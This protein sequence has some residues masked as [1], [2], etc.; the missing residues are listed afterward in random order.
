MISW[1]RNA[2]PALIAERNALAVT[3]G[4]TAKPLVVIVTDTPGLVAASEILGDAQQGVVYCRSS[5]LEAFPEYGQDSAMREHCELHSFF[6]DEQGA[7]NELERAR[8]EH[9]PGPGEELW[10]HHDETIMGPLFARGCGHLWLWNGREPRLVQEGWS[11]WI[12]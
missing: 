9:P 6:I 4:A 1:L 3:R 5:E 11:R 2:G 7:A 8:V 10:I 12:S